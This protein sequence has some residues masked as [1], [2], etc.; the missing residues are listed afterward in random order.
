MEALLH[1]LNKSYLKSLLWISMVSFIIAWVTGTYEFSEQ[2]YGKYYHLGWRIFFPV[3]FLLTGLIF[4]VRQIVVGFH[5]RAANI[6]LAL[7]WIF[8]IVWFLQLIWRHNGPV[9]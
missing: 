3:F 6:V 1:K 5:N 4:L 2:I 8:L 7:A 9:I